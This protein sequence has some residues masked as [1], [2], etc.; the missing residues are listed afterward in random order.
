MRPAVHH[1]GL[2]SVL[3]GP[4]NGK[5]LEKWGT[6]I[7]QRHCA[8]QQKL[9]QHWKQ[10]YCNKNQFKNKYSMVCID[11][12]L[13]SICPLVDADSLLQPLEYCQLHGSVFWLYI[14]K[15]LLDILF[16]T[17]FK[18]VIRFSIVATSF[19]ISTN[20]AQ[21]FQLSSILNHACYLLGFIVTVVCSER[22]HPDGC[23]VESHFGFDLPYPNV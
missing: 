20:T 6:Y 5:G 16:L 3:C 12:I 21:K 14:Q 2:C 19:Y 22:S 23:E 11:H 15:E 1:R 10:R 4:L 13:F 7:Q 8:V 9:T 17:F 18:I